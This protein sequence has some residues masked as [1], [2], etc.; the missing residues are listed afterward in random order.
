[1]NEAKSG[2]RAE[3]VFI[4]NAVS[5]KIEIELMPTNR[6]SF[7]G[8][9]SFQIEGNNFS[10]MIILMPEKIGNVFSKRVNGHVVY[11]EG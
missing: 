1:M 6:N 7:F 5:P 8:H 4:G 2:I 3:C 10:A 11:P 9:G